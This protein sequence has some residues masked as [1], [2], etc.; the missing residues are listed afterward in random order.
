MSEVGMTRGDV[1]VL[2]I[3]EGVT[4]N[5]RIIDHVLAVG[6]NYWSV[7]NWHDEAVEHILSFYDRDP[8]PVDRAARRIGYRVYPAFI[9][10]FGDGGTNGLV[11]GLANDGVAAP[12]GTVQLSISDAGGQVLARG[13]VDAGYPTPAGIRQAMLRLPLGIAWEGLHLRAELLVKDVAH[14]LKW[15]CRQQTDSNGALTLRRNVRAS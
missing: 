9:W 13:C 10:A 15:A 5:E 12:P 6:A 1:D 4:L 2:D 8:A 3:D 14:P 7:W 11:V